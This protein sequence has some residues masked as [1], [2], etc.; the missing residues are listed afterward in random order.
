MRKFSH[1]KLTYI[2]KEHERMCFISILK[3]YLVIQFI[4]EKWFTIIQQIL[5]EKLTIL[6]LIYKLFIIIIGSFQRI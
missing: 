5:F 3:I 4:H 6:L 2:F 1:T